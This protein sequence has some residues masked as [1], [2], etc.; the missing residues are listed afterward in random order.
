VRAYA[1]ILNDSAIDQKTFLTFLKSYHEASKASKYITVIFISAGIAGFAP[2][3]IA[4]AVTTA[5]QIAAGTAKEIQSRHRANS[6]LDEMNDKLFKPRGLYAIVMSFKPDASRPVS[7]GEFDPNSII[8]K[9][10]ES[11]SS[12][13]KDTTKKLR[14]TSGKT[15]GEM[16]LGE[17]APLIFPALE[18][19]AANTADQSKLKKAQK[20]LADYGD[21]RAQLSYKHQYG[22]SKLAVSPEPVK[23]HSRFSDPN[24]PANS[25]SIIS[26]ITGGAIDPRGRKMAKRNARREMFGIPKK[27]PNAG[28]LIKRMLREDVLYLMI[29]NM[30]SEEELAVAKQQLSQAK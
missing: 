6:F 4:M 8:A 9:Y 5:V 11:S 10:S 20:F 23:F 25:G 26:L 22:D 30:P 15:Y 13:F 18:D 2:S 19:A 14:V 7:A 29:V 12:K 17:V 24:H 1:P 27:D 3:V 16:E 28:G 21:K